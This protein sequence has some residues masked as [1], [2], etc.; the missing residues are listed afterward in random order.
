MRYDVT[1]GIPVFRSE[2][3]IRQALES[4]LSQSY[5]SI[6]YLI[7]DDC[8]G[9]NSIAIVQDLRRNHPR[10]N[11]IRILSHSE[12]RGV[13]AARNLI[14]N[15]ARG[16]YL[17]FMD[18]D[19]LIADN[20]IELLMQNIC[21]YQAE[22]AF[23]SYEKTDVSGEKTIYQYPSLQLLEEDALAS[24]A[25]RKYG[26][27][28]A[29]ACNFLVKVSLLRKHHLH[30]IDTNYWED[31]AFMFDLVPFVSRAV[32]LPNITYFYHCHEDSL[33][34]YQKRKIIPK[35]EIMKNVMTVNYLKES[36]RILYNK[37]Y[38]A[39]RCLNIVMTDFYMACHILKR[40]H[41]I[42][43]A[44]S[45]A[46]IK[47]MMSHPASFRQICSFRQARIKNLMIYF[48]GKLP[49]PLCVLV[50]WIVGKIKKL[51]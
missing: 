16:D 43:P 35:D 44:V 30:F 6:E 9:D 33:S 18:S 17:Y 25:Y 29:S 3:Y 40:I 15:E 32:L 11:H 12:N 38:F 5:P 23:G 4:A 27:I 42:V 24:F 50:I 20:T 39:N 21:Q 45:G 10:G 41:S 28:Q 19:D 14:I 13:S 36:T 2:D 8:G 31:M 49:I 22:I 34:Q 48:M 37:V 51:I 46:E 1:I 7:V 26:G 47:S